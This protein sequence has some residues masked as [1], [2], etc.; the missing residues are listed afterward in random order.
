MFTPILLRLAKTVTQLILATNGK[1][2][3]DF[4]M[5]KIKESTLRG[6]ENAGTHQADADP[7]H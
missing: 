6:H 3:F 2:G 1:S 5:C 4:Y 7:P